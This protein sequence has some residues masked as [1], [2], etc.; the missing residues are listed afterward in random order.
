MASP[1]Y[2]SSNKYFRAG[3]GEKLRPYLSNKC[4]V[5]QLID[6]GDAPVF[7]AIAYPS[8]I[9]LKNTQPQENTTIV[10]SWQPGLPLI[11]FASVVHSRSSP[12]PKKIL[13]PKV[14][15]WNHQWCNGF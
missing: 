14:G 13:L 5:P 12:M 11:E 2:I 3:Y 7:E 4:Q 1:T 15:D 10:F 8:I 6:F 9:V